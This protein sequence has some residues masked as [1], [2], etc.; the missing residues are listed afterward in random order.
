MTAATATIFP[1]AVVSLGE[2]AD[3]ADLARPGGLEP[4]TL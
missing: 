4:P 3:T 1:M 2:T